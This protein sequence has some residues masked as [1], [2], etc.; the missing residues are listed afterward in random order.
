MRNDRR[1]G[2]M[3]AGA[4]AAAAIAFSASA[5][6]PTARPEDVG[7]SAARL[8]RVDELMQR[9][10]D[11][12]TFAGAVTLVA[13]HGRVVHL[14]AQGLMDI[15][16]KRPM[17]TDAV[18][19]IM[20]MTKPIVAVAVL[21]MV[22]E[23]KVRLTDPVGRFIPEL[24]D[25]RVAAENGGTVA[26]ER[27][28]T[29]RD[30]L[31]HTSG[32]MSGGASNAQASTVAV[33]PGEGYEQV[34]PRL[35]QVP[36]DFQPGTRWS[37]SPQYGFDTLV[38]VVEIVSGQPFDAFAKARIFDPLGMKDTYFYTSEKRSDV[39]TLYRHGANGALEPMPEPS[40]MNGKYF[41]GG[42][43]LH[44]TA[45]DYLKLAS[46][47]L[48]GGRLGDA[49]LLGRRTVDLMTSVFVPASTP[50]RQ[51]GEGFGLGVRVVTDS[52]ARDTL[53]SPGT[54]GWSGAYNTHFFVDPSE[55]LVAI[56]MTQVAGLGAR[57][58]LRNDFETAVMQ[59]LVDDA[60][61]EAPPATSERSAP[62]DSLAAAGAAASH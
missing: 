12:G 33:R 20:S 27:P 62:K 16:S 15:A 50:G 29:I 56:Y 4:V 6:A 45:E 59:A 43:G 2:W 5:A 26:A 44:S 48:N 8:Q 32:L 40:F 38:H 9:E 18:F 41:S 37:Y 54:F 61:G 25:L 55:D 23:G 51:A 21:M 34:L 46:M 14:R 36:L 3:L 19:R 11:A 39:A 31:T 22:E 42:G 49:R 24:Q 10:I 60:P 53:V 47:L 35:K 57:F 1:V 28:I 17:Q 58:E 30:L 7:L 52:A 13:R